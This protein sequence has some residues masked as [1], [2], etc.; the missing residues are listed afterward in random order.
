MPESLVNSY[1]I[2]IKGRVQGVGFRP[3]IYR[4]AQRLQ[5]KGWVSNTLDGVH[6]EA[7]NIQNI[8][9]FCKTIKDGQPEQAKID[10]I[11]I[12]E[13]PFRDFEDF[14][15]IESKLEGTADMQLTPDFAMCQKCQEELN[16]PTNRRHQ[17]PF[18]TCTNCG[19]RYSIIRQLP[20]DR[21]FT[22]MSPIPACNTCIDEYE[23]P[24][25]RRFYSQTNSCPDCSIQLSLYNREK[26]ILT[27]EM[28]EILDIVS[29]AILSGRIVA[30]KGIGGY[31]L[32]ADASSVEA[33]LTLRT[34]KNRPSKPFALMYPDIDAA[35]QDVVL[36]EKVIS[37]WES[38]ESPIILCKLKK[39]YKSDLKIDAI[40]PG[41]MKMGI[42]MPYAPLFAILMERINKPIIATSGNVSGSP[43]IYND[44]E[45][46]EVLSKIA[47][48][49]LTNNREIVVPQ[50]DSVVLYTD[51]FDQRIIIRRSRGMS[52]SFNTIHKFDQNK[53]VLAMGAM[54]K[55][56]FG[57][58]HH[59][60]FYLSQF[61]GDTSILESQ[62][63]Y[64]ATLNHIMD[65]LN[66]KPSVVL[67][68][69]HPDYPSS[70]LG[71]EIAGKTGIPELKVQHH[72]AHSYAVLAENDLLKEEKVL[73]VVW[74]GTGF[75]TDGQIWGGE[76]FVYNGNQH[77]RLG[78]WEYFP[79]ILGDKM[80]K[81][82]RIS[83][84]CLVEGRG[85]YEQAIKDK[86]NHTELNNY[87]LIIKKE[88]L[89]TSSVGRIFDGVSSLL[90]IIDYATYEGEAAM[91]LE[92]LA[93]E[94]LES[95]PGFNEKY[96]IDISEKG[97]IQTY[98]MI[99][100]IIDDKLNGID[101][102]HIAL[103]FHISLVDVV[104]K[105]LIK[106]D[107]Q[108]AVFS[109]GVFQNSLLVDLIFATLS[110]KYS[111]Y[112]HRDLS[113]NDECIP[114]GQIVAYQKFKLNLK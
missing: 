32:C 39:D 95:H 16:N 99:S 31:L 91:I 98:D 79:H 114:F 47:D 62:I 61:L 27:T 84:L 35:R 46:L 44:Q 100:G 2:H 67:R 103:K 5:I 97:I 81:E 36:N 104:R 105:F 15:I 66:F 74:D 17:Y 20:Y 29:N 65:L 11:R 59:N 7:D 96:D 34:R 18:I 48:F 13:I 76:F 10:E 71:K 12:V 108:K 6:I 3:F 69:S 38:P 45:A 51:K 40:A 90:G 111:V 101:P 102:A 50:D 53:Q 83:A 1:H 56:T 68:D 21:R 106:F 26:E 64:E 73:S 49:I 41:L 24:E 110:D 75:G 57:L 54:L 113:P 80:S 55:S 52:P 107:L 87:K 37:E 72:E 77:K 92:A 8:D 89:R 25:N 109:G 112:F 82:P 94:Y 19:P 86:F 85:V 23:D 30:I 42:M 93:T 4:L 22:S 78:Q 60:R 43:I 33:I 14:S 70:L 28:D 58:T 88:G 9:I 63:S